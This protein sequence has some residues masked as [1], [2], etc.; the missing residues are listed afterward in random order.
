MKP[1][2]EIEIR[3]ALLN[4]LNADVEQNHL[5]IEEMSLESGG[6]R[7]DVAV[8]NDQLIGFEIK[9]DFDNLDRLSNQIHSYNRVFDEITLVAGD[10]FIGI[11][12]KILPA[13]WGLIRAT[14]LKNGSVILSSVR[15]P[16]PNQQQNSHSLASLLWKDEALGLLQKHL[17]KTPS[18]KLS[19]LKLYDL[20]TQV[21]SKEEIKMWVTSKLKTRATWR[22]SEPLKPNDG[23]LRHASM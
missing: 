14:R 5:L 1:I 13:W 20:I 2:A 18:S 6:A 3:S 7:V 4:F 12:E 21:T 17:T 10:E 22:S 19:K 15:E 23:L 16:A 11:A 9:S 8:V